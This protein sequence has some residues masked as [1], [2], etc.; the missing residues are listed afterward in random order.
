MQLDALSTAQILRLHERA[1]G[2][3]DPIGR[4]RIIETARTHGWDRTWETELLAA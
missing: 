1:F 3:L 4:Q 2:A